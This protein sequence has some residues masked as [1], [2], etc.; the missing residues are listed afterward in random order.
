[1]LDNTSA[2]RFR[3][4]QTTQLKS[5]RFGMLNSF[6]SSIFILR[7]DWPMS[8]LLG[9]APSMISKRTV[10]GFTSSE[11]WSR[12]LRRGS[13]RD[14]IINSDSI[15]LRVSVRSMQGLKEFIPTLSPCL[16]LFCYPYFSQYFYSCL[17]SSFSSRRMLE[18]N[19]QQKP[20]SHA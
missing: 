5:K 17:C 19:E 12:M 3:T 10:M 14:D 16:L 9:L 8:D 11:N 1:M 15:W 4:R 20:V 18:L 13:F 6:R 2:G 7:M